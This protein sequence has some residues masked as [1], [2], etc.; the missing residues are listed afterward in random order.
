MLDHLRILEDFSGLTASIG[1]DMHKMPR[2]ITAL[3]EGDISYD[4]FE[5][6][7]ARFKGND[8][9]IVYEAGP[10]GFDL[11]DRLRMMG[12]NVPLGCINKMAKIV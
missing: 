4:A 5:K 2:R 8:V 11:Y 10:G 7:L 12:M 1:I 3:V 9:R 6:I